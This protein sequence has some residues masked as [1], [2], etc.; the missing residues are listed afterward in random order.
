[1]EGVGDHAGQSC[2]VSAKED[3]DGEAGCEMVCADVGDRV[4]G[5]NTTRCM[6]RSRIFCCSSE[7]LLGVPF[8]NA[9]VSC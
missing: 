8:P 7:C 9:W 2:R 3:L 6:S 5:G 1:V 4:W